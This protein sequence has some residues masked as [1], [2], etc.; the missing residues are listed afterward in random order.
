MPGMTQV[1]PPPLPA[2]NGYNLLVVVGLIGGV[3]LV[4]AFF[5]AMLFLGIGK[6]TQVHRVPGERQLPANVPD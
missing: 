6:D 4:F 2:E 3:L 1:E 5:L